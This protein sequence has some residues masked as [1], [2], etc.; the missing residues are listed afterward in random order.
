MTAPACYT[1]L[2]WTNA[3]AIVALFALYAFVAWLVLRKPR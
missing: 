1:A 2:P 3:V